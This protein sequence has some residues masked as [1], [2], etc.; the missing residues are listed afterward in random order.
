MIGSGGERIAARTNP[1]PVLMGTCGWSGPQ[2]AAWQGSQSASADSKKSALATY[3]GH[4]PAVDVNSS[5]YAIPSC[6]TVESWVAF[7]AF[8]LMTN[9]AV[10][11][12]ALPSE[13]KA[14][15]NETQRGADRV[16][17]DELEAAGGLELVW[18]AYN[19]ALLVAYK[20]SQAS[21]MYPTVAMFQFPL[22]FRPTVGIVGVDRPALALRT[23]GVSHAD[24]LT[25]APSSALRALLARRRT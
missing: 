23:P 13:V 10:D 21:G 17:W 5:N 18:Q 24:A 11:P 2:L 19:D 12:K 16:T 3:A 15:I 7:K 22:S 8:G 14:R 20:G 1:T 4:W 25:R 6:S 9:K